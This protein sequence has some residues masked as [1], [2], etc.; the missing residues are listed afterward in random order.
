M[1]PGKLEDLYQKVFDEIGQ[2]VEINDRNGCCALRIF[3]CILYAA[4]PLEEEVFLCAVGLAVQ[5]PPGPITKEQVLDMCYKLVEFD[6]QTK[7]FRFIHYTVQQSPV[8]HPRFS[9]PAKSH[10]KYPWQQTVLHIAVA[11]RQ[12]EVVA[13]LI[14]QKVDLESRDYNGQ[15][16]IFA[17]IESTQWHREFNSPLSLALSS[18][19]SPVKD[20]VKDALKRQQAE[21][22]RSPQRKLW[23]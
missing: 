8:K 17:A 11:Q 5:F 3:N 21:H 20:L 22:A 19:N 10:A 15:N 13:A 9:S 16:P 4:R 1:L 6:S 14:E 18:N 7:T 12:T 2:K 23:Q